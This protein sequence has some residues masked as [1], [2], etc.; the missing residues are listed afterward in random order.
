MPTGSATSRVVLPAT[1]DCSRFRVRVGLVPLS[2]AVDHY[3]P[4]DLTKIA[5]WPHSGPQAVVELV[6]G[7]GWARIGAV[8]VPRPLGAPVGSAPRERGLAGAPHALPGRLA[9]GLGYDCL[10]ASNPASL[11]FLARRRSGRRRSTRR[12]RLSKV[13]AR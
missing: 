5:D 4:L 1:V 7:G 11:E 12:R 10:G 2:Q 3:R 8:R 13:K 6:R 9:L